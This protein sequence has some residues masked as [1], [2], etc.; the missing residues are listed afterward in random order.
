MAMPS[1]ST[2]LDQVEQAVE[3][4]DVGRASV[5]CEP[6]W[7]SMPT[8]SMPGSCAARAVTRPRAS[9]WAMPNLLPR[10]PVEM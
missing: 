2:R 5:I 10:R 4:L 6:M 3:R 9:V 8:T 1:A 7:Q